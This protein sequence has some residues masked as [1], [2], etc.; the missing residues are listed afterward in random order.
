MKPNKSILDPSFA[1]TSAA[2][3]SVLATWRRF[4]WAPVS[5]Q[6]RTKKAE[7]SRQS[8]DARVVDLASRRAA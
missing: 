4:G 8:G 7:D 5:D 6:E 1:Y 3:T 2:A